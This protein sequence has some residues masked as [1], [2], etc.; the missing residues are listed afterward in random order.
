MIRTILLSALTLVIAMTIYLYF[1]LG[2][3]KPVEIAV[4]KRGP[5]YMLYKEHTGPYHEIGPSIS[6]VESW[7]REHKVN[8]AKT[9]GE[10]LDDPEAV[11]QDRLRSHGGCLLDSRISA[12][13]DE[14]HF[15]ERGERNYVVAH[16]TGSPAIGPMKV[17]PKVREYISHE[18]LKS[19]AAVIE[20]YLIHGS[21]VDTEYLFPL[22]SAN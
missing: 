14:F 7:A 20:I 5:L 12:A 13:P 2:F 1:Y 9:F 8:C 4:A 17:Y 3:Y 16:F 21:Q 18:R 10:Y 22:E 19:S 15:E 6:A 11:D